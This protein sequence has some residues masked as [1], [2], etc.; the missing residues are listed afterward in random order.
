M[1][2]PKVQWGCYVFE[3]DENLYCPACF[4]TKG[5]K[6]LT[7]RANSQMRVCSVCGSHLFSG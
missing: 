6:H 7:T 5:K 1:R 4:D 2:K 3:G